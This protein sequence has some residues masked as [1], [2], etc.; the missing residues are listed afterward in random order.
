MP[1]EDT[2]GQRP[3]FWWVENG[4]MHSAR[5]L[6]SIKFEADAI[7]TDMSR[8]LQWMINDEPTQYVPRKVAAMA[9]RPGVWYLMAGMSMV[10]SMDLFPTRKAAAQ[11]EFE[12]LM[13]Q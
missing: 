13:A 5:K 6:G 4:V 2:Q 12:R 10:H 9:D 1:P 7:D 8:V 11:A 3:I